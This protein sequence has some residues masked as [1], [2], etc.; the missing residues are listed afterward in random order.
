MLTLWCRWVWCRGFPF[1][2]QQLLWSE[3]HTN[4]SKS[5]L[6]FFSSLFQT[7]SFFLADT[8]FYS[9]HHTCSYIGE[10]SLSHTLAMPWLS[11]GNRNVI[12]SLMDVILGMMLPKRHTPCPHAPHTLVI[13][14]SVHVEPHSL[15]WMLLYDNGAELYQRM[16]KCIQCIPK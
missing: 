6:T 12:C 7:N 1:I 11:T 5:T 4:P 8:H 13:N 9:T 16:G 3:V 10:K 15:N 2:T 14:G